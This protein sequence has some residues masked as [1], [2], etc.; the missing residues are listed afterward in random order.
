MPGNRVG[1]RTGIGRALDVL[2]AA[3]RAILNYSGD[4]KAGHVLPSTVTLSLVGRSPSRAAFATL[5]RGGPGF[6]DDV[7]RCRRLEIQF[8]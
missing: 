5:V 8:S 6:T 1:V 2:R 3:G 4:E 7:S